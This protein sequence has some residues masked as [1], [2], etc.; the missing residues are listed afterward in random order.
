MGLQTCHVGYVELLVVEVRR[1]GT[2]GSSLVACEVLADLLRR[3]P[4]VGGPLVWH[5]DHVTDGA[6]DGTF[7]LDMML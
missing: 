6:G 5:G 1:P 3:A 4:R 2:A 7:D